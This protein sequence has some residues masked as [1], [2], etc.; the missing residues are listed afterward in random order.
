MAVLHILLRI[1]Y[2]QVPEVI[3]KAGRNDRFI[4]MFKA[5]DQK[6]AIF[7]SDPAG[8]AKRPSMTFLSIHCLDDDRFQVQ[9]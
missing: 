1:K 6:L 4:W 5:Q 9:V 8:K 2:V 3:D 7:F